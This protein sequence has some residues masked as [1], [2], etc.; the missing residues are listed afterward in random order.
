MINGLIY[1]N[2]FV[3]NSVQDHDMRL[4]LL[5]KRLIL[6]INIKLAQHSFGQ[7]IIQILIMVKNLLSMLHCKKIQINV[8][9]DQFK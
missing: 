8:M 5:S 4:V 6:T 1:L 3:M 9:T 2:V 7:P